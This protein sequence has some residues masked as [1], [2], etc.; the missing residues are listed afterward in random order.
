MKTV[1]VTWKS[2]WSRSIAAAV[3]KSFMFDAGASGVFGLRSA[4]IVPLSTSTTCRLA[5]ELFAT[6]PFISELMRSASVAPDAASAGTAGAALRARDLLLRRL[7][8]PAMGVSR[9][10][11]SANTTN[12]VERTVIECEEPFSNVVARQASVYCT[13]RTQSQSLIRL[14][15]RQPDPIAQYRRTAPANLI[16]NLAPRIPPAEVR[17]DDRFV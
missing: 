17:E 1:V 10:K 8:A 7:A 6:R 4:T 3:V 2:G 12:R 14:R 16:M 5:L 11:R 13:P 15:Q 9:I